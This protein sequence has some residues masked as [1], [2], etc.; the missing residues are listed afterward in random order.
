ME[1]GWVAA[2]PGAWAHRVPVQAGD[3]TVYVE[4]VPLDDEEEITARLFALEDFTGSIAT[5]THAVLDGVSAGLRKVRPN[6]V[7]LE[8]GCEV[9]VESGKLT[10][11]LVKGT[12]KANVKVTMEWTPDG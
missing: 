5:V 1:E 7:T 12:A 4:V 6:K 9:G 10:T 2:S 8:F 11:V 3:R